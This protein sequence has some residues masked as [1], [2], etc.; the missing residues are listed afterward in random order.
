MIHCKKEVNGMPNNLLKA[1]KTDLEQ[2][3]K[4]VKTRENWQAIC[5]EVIMTIIRS[6]KFYNEGFN[7]TAM[8]VN[9]KPKEA[10]ISEIKSHVYRAEN[11][12]DYGTLSNKA[13][14][15]IVNDIF[16]LENVMQQDIVSDIC[17]KIDTIN[18]NSN[19]KEYVKKQIREGTISDDELRRYG[20]ITEKEI[21]DYHAYLNSIGSSGMTNYSK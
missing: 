12:L 8:Y 18:A 3:Y 21:N 19:F 4:P 10:V 6:R 16:D 5:S 20:I 9:S 14:T 13:A 1:L 7:C 2:N 11:I 15:A 17:K